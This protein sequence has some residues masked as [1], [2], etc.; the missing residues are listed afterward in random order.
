VA[1]RGDRIEDVALDEAVRDVKR[2]PPDLFEVAEVF[3]G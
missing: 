1:L 2:V 3:F